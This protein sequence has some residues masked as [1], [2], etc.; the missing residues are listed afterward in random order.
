M[1][2]PLLKKILCSS[3]IGLAATNALSVPPPP[4]SGIQSNYFDTSVRPQDD[5]FRYVNGSWLLKTE[6]PADESSFSTFRQLRNESEEHIKAIIDELA[7]AKQLPPGS[8]EQKVADLY[9]SFM[10]QELIEQL[11]INFVAEDIAKVDSVKSWS[12][13]A[14]IWAAPEVDGPIG[15]YVSL[16]SKN[17]QRY[18]V[19]LWQS[20]LSLPDRDY[21][22]SPEPRFVELRT[23]LANHVEKM[24][25]LAGWSDGKAHAAKIMQIE[26]AL[27]TKHWTKVE[28][29]DVNKT[30]NLYKTADLA[31]QMGAF[32]LANFLEAAGFGDQKDLIVR[33][34]TYLIELPK[35]LAQFSLDDWKTYTK[36]KILSDASPKMAKVFDDENFRFY[37]SILNGQ[38]EQRPRWK[39]GVAMANGVLGEVL[40]RIY[41]KKHFNAAAKER[42]MA[43]VNN[44]CKAYAASIDELTWMSPETKKF[45][46]VK[47]EKFTPKI[48]YPDRWHDFSSLTIK[49]D[50]LPGNVK[51]MN[52][53]MR[54]LSI[55]RLKGPVQRWEWFMDPQVVNAYYNP[56]MNE[57]VF[58]AAILQPPFFSATADDAVNYGGI[59][60]VIGHEMG[61][62][63][64]DQGSEFDGDG[65]LKNWWTDADKK[66]FQT[67]TKILVQQF[68]KFEP[69]KGVRVNGELT[70]GENIGDLSGVS[71]A[72]KAYKISLGQ[73]PAPVLDNLTGDQRF[74]IGYAQ[75]WRS[76]FRDQALQNLI[77]TN[78]HAP[79]EYRVQGILPNV[80][81]FYEAFNITKNDKM[82]LPPE[83]RVKIW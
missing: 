57:I 24:F 14:K 26:T 32:P 47:L 58:P 43:L 61:H 9:R 71:I 25:A 82:Y 62:A 30:Y 27:A 37:G 64:D 2:I 31:K 34:P 59:G 38:A 7:R 63:F 70:L 41:V 80:D 18:V 51:R 35:I 66:T 21:F 13:L 48:G 53:F 83:Q 54:Q 52:E 20:G 8:D 3:A 81:A 50:D 28:N 73:K 6:I 33:Q 72:Y 46:K 19:Y 22:T 56:E 39:R 42:M 15:T 49:A 4:A 55:T 40:G 69:L 74:F 65:N 67:K 11:G 1:E 77:A 78:P 60:A 79:G 12:D 16:D 5:F 44:I 29:R 75:I 17:A 76:K 10:N 45:A 23:G 36:W 68:G